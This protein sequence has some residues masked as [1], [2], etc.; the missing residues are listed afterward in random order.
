M[1]A[2]DKTEG[3][4]EAAAGTGSYSHCKVTFCSPPPLQSHSPELLRVSGWGVLFPT[5]FLLY[6]Q[7]NKGFWST[8]SCQ[9]KS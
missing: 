8:L 6:S 1:V 9:Q 3:L 4:E 7:T 5:H 2:R